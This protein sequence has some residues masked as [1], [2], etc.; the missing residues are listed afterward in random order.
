VGNGKWLHRGEQPQRCA[1]VASRR[2]RGDRMRVGLGMRCGKRQ[3]EGVPTAPDPTDGP[4]LIPS[5]TETA[6]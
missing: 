5:Q 2:V 1:T 6:L 3:V 4:H